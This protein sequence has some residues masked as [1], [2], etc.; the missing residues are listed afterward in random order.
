[1]FIEEKEGSIR[2]KL[3]A[4]ELLRSNRTPVFEFISRQHKRIVQYD[5]S[6]LIL[7]AIR[8][9]ITG[10]Y[11]QHNQLLEEC[12]SYHIPVSAQWP[13]PQSWDALEQLRNLVGHE[14]MCLGWW[15]H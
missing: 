12:S 15:C 8:D 4:E 7:L 13:V 10:R 5:K 11:V 14:G 9:N 6:D 1:M 2:Y 3:F